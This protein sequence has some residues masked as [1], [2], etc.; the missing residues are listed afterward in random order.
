[1]NARL[2]CCV[3]ALGAGVASAQV[4]TPTA[5]SFALVFQE[6]DTATT[7]TRE[8]TFDS[9]LSPGVNPIVSDAFARGT[10]TPLGASRYRLTVENIAS[11]PDHRVIEVWYPYDRSALTIGTSAADDAILTPWIFGV[12]VK[13]TRGGA[14]WWRVGGYPGPYVSPLT[15]MT[16]AGRARMYAA[17]NWPPRH[18]Q[19]TFRAQRT[20]LVYQGESISP[21]Q[22]G[23]YEAIVAEAAGSAGSVPWLTLVDAY[24]A[25][26]RP[27]MQGDGLWPVAY[28]QWMRDAH[29]YYAVGL[30]DIP[31]SNLPFVRSLFDF[32]SD[33]LPWAQMWGQMSCLFNGNYNDPC[34]GCCHSNRTL[35]PR[36]TASPHDIRDFAD[37][38]RDAGFHA[39]Y[40][41]AP[42][43]GYTLDQVVPDGSGLTNRDWFLGWVDNHDSWNASAYYL[44]TV[45]WVNFGDV[46][47]MATLLRDEP[48]F[49]NALI[50]GA[51]DI[52]PAANMVS[53]SLHYPG[54]GYPGGPGN[55]FWDL[56]DTTP[57]VSFAQLGTALIDDH[58]IFNGTSNTGWQ[59]WGPANQYWTERQVFLLGHKYETGMPPDDWSQPFVINQAFGLA[60]DLR[61]QVGW[62]ARQP[63]Y[64]DR[65][66][67]SSLP[68]GVDARRF[69]DQSGQNLVCVDNWSQVLGGTIAFEGQTLDV[70]TQRLSIL[71]PP[72]VVNRPGVVTSCIGAALTTFEVQ[73][74]GASP[75]TIQW[76]KN[77]QPIFDGPTG[78]GSTYYGTVNPIMRIGGVQR[79]DQGT[80]DCVATN[81]LG[82]ATSNPVDL[83]LCLADVDNGSGVGVCDGGVDISDL[84]Y[85]LTLFDAG[86]IEADLD[87]GSATGTP[88]G[89]V[90][91][92]DL[93]YFL[94]R[95]DAGC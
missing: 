2:A 78:F 55:T 26:L 8:Y 91:I 25:W 77:G 87:D 68:G 36:W 12:A 6:G 14:G 47:D 3:L 48:R 94:V 42:Y 62:W 60:T 88:D 58:A 17:T 59:L 72:V 34:Y 30:Q 95:F 75:M 32:Y 1:M 9:A 22:S 49:R 46:M 57:S 54:A 81:A 33:R 37:D 7:F 38:L 11:N 84:L 52:Y 76:R 51:V 43:Y 86:A 93:L 35:H 79:G 74:S 31:E 21:S 13:S 4:T 5:Q 40:Y 28:P 29:G 18:V 23:S 89:A 56:S 63:R 66:G 27:N 70:P 64:R 24:K 20:A 67:I 61:D 19:P 15:I 69:V 44:D 39:G 80:Y 53:L 73:V 16:D 85:Y 92:S 10:L 65:L 50:E 71:T 45:G 41:A 82:S 83:V 90:D